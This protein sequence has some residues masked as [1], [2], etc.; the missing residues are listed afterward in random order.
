MLF[1]LTIHPWKHDLRDQ[2]LLKYYQQMTDDIE[3][4]FPRLS[5]KNDRIENQH[6]KSYQYLLSAAAVQ[7]AIIK[8]ELRPP[9]SVK[10]AG[11]P[12]IP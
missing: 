6:I 12:L 3:L 7:C 8:P 5:T 2:H 10:K 9:S 4:Y 11:K 1:E